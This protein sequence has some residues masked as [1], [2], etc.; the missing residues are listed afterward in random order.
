MQT[1]LGETFFYCSLEKKPF[2]SS[3]GNKKEGNSF[4]LQKKKFFL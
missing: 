1:P 3:K 2:F 4:F